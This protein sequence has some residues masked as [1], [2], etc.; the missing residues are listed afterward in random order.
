M[1]EKKKLSSD[2]KEKLFEQIARSKREWQ[3]TFD[4][5]TD[6]IHIRDKESRIIKANRKFAEYF[7]LEPREV[8]HK[9]CTDL[10]DETGLISLGCVYRDISGD[11][12]P[13]AEDA[14]DPNTEKTFRITTFPYFSSEG[15]FMGSVHIA[16]DVTEER[17]KEMRL[18]MSERLASLGQMASGIAHEINN[19]LASIAGCAEGLLKRLQKGQFDR[20]V[21]ES[22]L[23]IVEEEIARCKKITTGMLSI[24]RRSVSEK[25]EIDINRILDKMLEI[26]GFQDRLKD[27]RIVKKYNGDMPG[28]QGSESELRQVFM[29]IIINALDAMNDRGVLTL[30]TE[31]GNGS[32]IIKINDNGCGIEPDVI[33]R[34]FTPFFTTRSDKGGI[35][36]GLSIARKIVTDHNGE[37]D[38]SS[39]GK[40]GTTFRIQLPT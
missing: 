31:T 14:Y 5:I 27:I 12:P 26:I 36:L 25:T 35:G 21:F 29:T 4:S 15:D 16:R 18:I 28:V 8:I 32:I 38:V 23:K 13:M 30:S 7:G 39:G 2:E 24:V 34:I 11:H 17:E 19:P 1:K 40:N 6:S 33:N 10:A 3:A 37:I 20:D 9:K 22:Y